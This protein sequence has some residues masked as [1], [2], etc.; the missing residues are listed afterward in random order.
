[1]SDHDRLLRAEV[2]GAR[3]TPNQA[4]GLLFGAGN[5]LLARQRQN[6]PSYQYTVEYLGGL[7]DKVEEAEAL[8]RQFS[9]VI[10]EPFA[11]IDVGQAIDLADTAMTERYGDPDVDPTPEAFHARTGMAMGRICIYA[12]WVALRSQQLNG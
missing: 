1:M 4:W 6:Y 5:N 10:D 8:H 7:F 2:M 9:S 11:P 3:L 12:S